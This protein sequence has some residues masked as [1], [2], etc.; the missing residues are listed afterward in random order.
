MRCSAYS[1]LRHKFFNVINSFMVNFDK[2]T[3]SDQFLLHMRSEDT[4]SLSLSSFHWQLF[5]HPLVP[6]E[7]NAFNIGMTD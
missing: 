5:K 6:R 7:T 3:T 2:L 1:D 4:E